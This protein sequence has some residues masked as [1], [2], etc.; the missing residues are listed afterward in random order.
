MLNPAAFWF[1]RHGE[2]DWNAQGL[3]QGRTDVPLNAAGIAQAHRAAGLLHGRGIERVVSSTLGRAMDTARIAAAALDLPFDTDPELQEA[4]FGTE[5][6][7]VMGTWYDSWVAGTYLPAG[8]ENFAD[9]RTRVRTVINRIT[10][11]PGLALIVAHGS[12]FRAAR[13]E[14]GLSARVR[15]PNGVP[16]LCQPGSPSW[17]LVPA[18]PDDSA[19]IE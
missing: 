18:S 17:T 2:T 5:E 15:T 13:A 9:L 16:L 1:L 12:M 14:M 8:A 10:A 3:S 7:Q 19:V 4:S 11:A 6:G